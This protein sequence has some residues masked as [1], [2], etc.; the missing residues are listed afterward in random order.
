VDLEWRQLKH[1]RLSNV[2][3]ECMAKVGIGFSHGAPE[4]PETKWEKKPTEGALVI[5]TKTHRP[6]CD[7]LYTCQLKR[8]N[9]D[10]TVSWETQSNLTR[11]EVERIPWFV[12]FLAGK[13]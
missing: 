12:D 4:N 10:L 9:T 13:L 7:F 1:N 6:G 11:D 8:G 5:Y 2:V 3:E